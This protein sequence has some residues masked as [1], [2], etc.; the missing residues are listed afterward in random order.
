MQAV[1]FDWGGVLMRTEDPVPRSLWERQLGIPSGTLETSVHGSTAWTRVQQGRLDTNGFWEE[2]ARQLHIDPEQIP[3]F[4]YDFYR[5][6]VLDRDLIELIRELRA[7]GVVIGLLSNNS[8]DLLLEIDALRIG[9]FFDVIVISSQI[10]TLKP[11]P[12]AYQAVLQQLRTPPH[13]A[14]LIDDSAQNVHGARAL[15][16]EAIHYIPGLD[17][18]HELQRWFSL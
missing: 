11:E 1:I 15:G 13:N 9:P 18:R 6:D 17:V 16:M 3:D 10:G 12:A 14:L 4:R 7:R 2:I 5:G 8:S